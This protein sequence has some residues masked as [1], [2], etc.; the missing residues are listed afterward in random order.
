MSLLRAGDQ[1]QLSDTLQAQSAVR[2]RLRDL[3]AWISLHPGED[4]SVG[5]LAARAHMSERQFAR[6]FAAE[7]GTTPARFVGSAPDVRTAGFASLVWQ[8]WVDLRQSLVGH[9]LTYR[10]LRLTTAPVKF[11]LFD[12]EGGKA[13]GLVGLRLSFV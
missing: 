12:D 2:H 4:L 13:R 10:G 1:A 5:A 6:S 3:I 11:Q 9:K 7:A 8:V